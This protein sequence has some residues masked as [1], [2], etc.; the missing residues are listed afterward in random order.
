VDR[1]TPVSIPPTR[2][3]WNTSLEREINYFL[4]LFLE[5]NYEL[6]ASSLEIT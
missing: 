2:K 1:D 3:V 6:D 4:T 5:Q